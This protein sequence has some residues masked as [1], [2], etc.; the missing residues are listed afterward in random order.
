MLTLHAWRPLIP[1]LAWLVLNVNAGLAFALPLR[2]RLWTLPA[3]LLPAYVSFK[4][5]NYLTLPPGLAAVWGYVTVL[6][7][8]HF[9]SLLYIKQWTLRSGKDEDGKPLSDSIWPTARSWKRMYRITSNPRLLNTS[10]SD[11]N[12]MK[13]DLRST[14]S[15][16][17]PPFSLRT[18][19]RCVV[20]WLIHVFIIAPLF[21][22]PFMPMRTDD[23]A[24]ARQLY[25]RRLLSTPF[26]EPS[27]PVTSRETLLRGI[28]AF[29]SFWTTVLVLET[30]N[31]VFAIFWVVV[32]RVSEPRDW[33]HL[34]G[35]PLEAYTLGRFWSR[36]VTLI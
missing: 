27:E 21:P 23:F 11:V 30:V 28:F 14:F 13:G 17:K 31:T 33:P 12:G 26:H 4:T 15:S 1:I 18:I 35:S 36:L 3:I 22:G 32:F 10:T 6:G 5:I 34:F 8:F 20:G 19:C 29:Q 25:F 16:T 9:T 7:L 2:Y 24:A